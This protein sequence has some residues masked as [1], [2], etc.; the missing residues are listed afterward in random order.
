MSCASDEGTTYEIRLRGRLDER[1]LDWLNG[2]TMTYGAEPGGQ[3]TTIL[4]GDL[5]QAALRGLLTRLW[6]LNVSV[7]SVCDLH[8]R[9]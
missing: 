5:D 4:T 9:G 7:I 6:D 2:V 8:D 3:G 1:W